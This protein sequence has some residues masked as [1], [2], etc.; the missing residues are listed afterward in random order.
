MIGLTYEEMMALKPC[1]EQ[2]KAVTKLLGGAKTWNGKK[3]SAR[4][5]V[6]AG[7][8]YSDLV[9]AAS[10]Q[11]RN[12][13]DVE[14]RLRLWLADCAAHVLHI[15]E[16][17]YPDDRRPRDAIVA[18]RAYARGDTTDA[19]KAAAWDAAKAAAWDAAIA[20]ARDAA[21]AAARDAAWDAARAAAM[22]AA[23]EAAWAATRGAASATEEKWQ[24]DRLVL[25]LSD[26][27][28]TDWNPKP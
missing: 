13:K 21:I 4:E 5:A 11:A 2:A 22:N 9:W 19:A 28:P 17:D 20:A 23:W 6:K 10:T 27:E 26:K 7:V 1:R 3:I 18:G 14:R 24:L 25:W 12:D 8:S 15:Y 16:K